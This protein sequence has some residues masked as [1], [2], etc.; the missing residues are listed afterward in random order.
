MIGAI[1]GDIVGSRFEFHNTNRYNFTLFTPECNF[2]DDTICT[3]AIADAI[4]TGKSYKQSLLDWCHK[5]PNPM[6]GYGGGFLQWLRSDDPQPYNSYGNGAAMRVSPVAWA[7]NTL[8]EVLCEA[9]NTAIVTHNHPEGIKGAKCVAHAIYHLRMTKD[10][11]GL[12]DVVNQYYPGFSEV[13]YPRGVFDE[14]CQGTVPLC[15]KL[16]LNS[17]SFEDAIRQAI[18]YGGD[19]DTIGAIVGSMAE[20]IWGIPDYIVQEAAKNLTNDILDAINS[21]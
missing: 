21:F 15:C 5:Y 8:E 20:A 6:G 16:V 12:K 13:E 18:S 11:D 1:I 9:E 4:K 10:I 2:T 3:V 7:Y 17:R 19:S 14:S